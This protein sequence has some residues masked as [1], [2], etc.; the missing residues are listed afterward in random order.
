MKVVD[1]LESTVQML[2]TNFGNQHIILGKPYIEKHKVMF[3]IV[4]DR[5]IFAPGYCKH[6]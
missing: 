1:Y 4:E 5:I 3:D 2:I 6:N